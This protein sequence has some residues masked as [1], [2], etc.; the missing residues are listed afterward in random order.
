MFVVL[1]PDQAT[2]RPVGIHGVGHDQ[3]VAIGDDVEQVDAGGAAVE[4][5]DSVGQIVRG[6]E[7]FH[8]A[9]AD[10]LI[11]QEDVAETED[12]DAHDRASLHMA[13]T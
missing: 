7:R 13:L 6:I 3:A 9:H 10:A 8:D 2:G 11:R 12:E 4:Q 1:E 5:V